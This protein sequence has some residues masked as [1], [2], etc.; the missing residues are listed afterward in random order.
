VIEAGFASGSGRAPLTPAVGQSVVKGDWKVQNRTAVL[1]VAGCL[2]AQVMLGLAG[3]KPAI[4][5]Q[6][7]AFAV[8]MNG[9]FAFAQL[10]ARAPLH[11]PGEEAIFDL[12]LRNRGNEPWH[13]RYCVELL[14][15][16][17]SIVVLN[18]DDVVLQPG[19][20]LTLELRG[21]LPDDLPVG[22]YGLALVL[23]GKSLVIGSLPIGNAGE[24]ST[25]SWPEPSCW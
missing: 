17:R 15:D 22:V 23:P 8:S 7:P 13:S 10:A 6:T 25:G 2:G 5:M 16:E 12:T 14:N 9:D 20:E 11:W 3:C 19:G 4:T 18:Q 24:A 1:T 21:R